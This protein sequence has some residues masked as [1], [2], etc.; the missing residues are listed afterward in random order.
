M[1]LLKSLVLATSVVP[2]LI[3]CGGGGG[4]GGAVTSAAPQPS[5]T[6]T[7]T[8]TPTPPPAPASSQ[9]TVSGVVVAG[10][11][12]CD[13]ELENLSS[14]LIVSDGSGTDGQFVL[15]APADPGVYILSAS[16][17]E[18]EDEL[19][20]ERVTGASFRTGLVLS[21]SDANGTIRINL[22]PISEMSLRGA[23]ERAGGVN[24][25]SASLLSEEIGRF[26][27]LFGG[28]SF[29]PAVADPIIATDRNSDR[30]NSSGERFGLV[31]A[32]ISGAGDVN[33][34]MTDLLAE[35][36]AVTGTLSEDG[37]ALLLDGALTFENSGRSA[38]TLP[39]PEVLAP[40]TANG[41]VSGTAPEFTGEGDVI[42]ARRDELLLVDLKTFFF[43][44]DDIIT[45]VVAAGLPDGFSVSEGVLSAVPSQVQQADLT[46]T[47]FDGRGNA[48]SG[49]LTL[50]VT[51]NVTTPPTPDPNPDAESPTVTF[52]PAVIT[53]DAATSVTSVLDAQDNVGVTSG[54]NV[55]CTN[56]GM[57]SNNVF[58]APSSDVDVQ[59]VCTA[60]ARDAA[61]NEGT[62]TLI[63]NV[64]GVTQLPPPPSDT[65]SP[66]LAFIPNVVSL[67]ARASTFSNLS[68]SD[69]IGV[70]S[71]P[72][73]VCTNGGMFAD[74]VFTAPQT[75]GDITSICTATASDAA[76]NTGSVTLT[77]TIRGSGLS[78]TTAP[79]LAFSPNT[80]IVESN[81]SRDS[82]LNANDDVAITLGPVVTCTNGGTWSNNRFTAPDTETDITSVCTAM[83]SDA[84]GNT[85]QAT[86][87]V[88]VNGVPDTGDTTPPV[89]TFTPNTLT[90]ESQSVQ[91]AALAASDDIAITSGPAVTC[92]NGGTWAN[93]LFTAPV[94]ETDITSVCTATASDA[95][96]NTGQATLQ[97]SVTAVPDSEDTTSP[98][99]SFSPN[100]LTV[101]SESV[102]AVTLVASDDV[103]ITSGPNVT[104]TAGG[105]FENNQFTAPRTTR[106]ITSVCTA[107]AQDAAGNQGQAILTV[108]VTGQPSPP[109]GEFNTLFDTRAKASR[110]LSVASFGGNSDDL[111]ALVGTRAERW[112]DTQFAKPHRSYL[113]RTQAQIA[114]YGGDLRFA[115]SHRVV[116]WDDVIAGDDPLRNRMTFA[117]SQIVVASEM[118]LVND[119]RRM[120]FYMDAIGQ[121]A[122][123]N[124]RDLLDDVTYTPAMAQYL[125]YLGN[126]RGNPET[127]RMPDENYAREILQL[128]S[129]GINELNMDGTVKLRGD[130]TVIETYTNEDIVGLARVF[131]G[132]TFNESGGA[133]GDRFAT[134]LLMTTQGHS[135][136]EK[137]FL[138][139]TIPAN[140][141]GDPSIDQAIDIIFAHPNVAPFVSRQLIQRFTASNPE[142]AYVERVAN[143]FETGTFVAPDGTRYGSTGRGDLEATLAAILL[144]ESQH[145]DPL[146]MTDLT[147]IG[148]VRE[149]VLSFIHWARAFEVS[150]PVSAI[151]DLLIFG[152][153]DPVQGLGQQ[154]FAAPSVFN[155]FR[156]GF[157]PDGTEAGERDLTMPE[158]QLVDGALRSGYVNFM[159]TFVMGTSRKR[160]TDNQDNFLPNLSVI[161]PLVEDS[162][163]LIEYLDEL[164]LY[165]R[166]TDQTRQNIR[167][168]NDNV[169][170]RGDRVDEDRFKRAQLAVL[171]AV[172]APEFSVQQ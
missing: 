88:S 45:R 165:G 107:V 60:G 69:N 93:N 48:V 52:S 89:L 119:P 59:V 13:V 47:A 144:D 12:E 100:T 81:T 68:A 1:R 159:T 73:V 155:F 138:G 10:L 99:V 160:L 80:L 121:N 141:L 61:G 150:P 118:T 26:A 152:T 23:I 163:A 104:C 95:A 35:Y 14:N 72:S 92:T 74:G 171:V 127:G 6:P 38:A 128:F 71:G 133:I 140:T 28:L 86:L 46:L 154:A 25:L 111:D 51:E 75:E 78:D 82:V 31:L 84:A 149:P 148:K 39:A 151:E 91:T 113:D 58:T 129:I 132:L 5:F 125:T 115:G 9:V 114:A 15:T 169:P 21:D 137:S 57:F 79:V 41:E 49:R 43:D 172:T 112:L 87:Q 34:V 65:E 108:A 135:N 90:V 136:L 143:A 147:D 40:L 42:A 85:G 37:V 126:M 16:N 124:Y 2:F 18:Y 8:P 83:A 33:S 110:F 56:G 29:D 168:V 97:V 106:D 32:A 167:E 134:R 54:P 162:G 139:S 7:P 153:Q 17:C 158:M 166:M 66:R 36:D 170:I 123:G 11:A 94:T 63:A 117:L 116:F 50:E 109:A 146:E 105:E 30:T 131:T 122:F 120:A 27:T 22:S 98:V 55:S 156:P 44:A 96:G 4:G 19:T 3:A 62:A 77:A 157:I 103:A 101:G 53:L 142:P 67:D 24:N 102:Q 70:T 161:I 20:G 130:G 76:G 145:D 164:L 64:N